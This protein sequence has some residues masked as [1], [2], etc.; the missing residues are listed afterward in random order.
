MKTLLKQDS[1]FLHTTPTLSSSQKLILKTLNPEL[2]RKLG[3]GLVLPT[4]ALIEGPNDSGKSVLCYQLC[5]GA[6]NIGFKVCFVT[7]E[8]SIKGLINA[9]EGLNFNVKYHFLAGNLKVIELHVEGLKWSKEVSKQYLNILYK[10]M[11]IASKKYQI[12]FVDSL[13]YIITNAEREDI[14]NFF[15]SILNLTEKGS[16]I[17]IT[18]HDYALDQDLMIRIRSICDTHI[19]LSIKEVSGKIMRLLKIL[20]AKGVEK[21]ADSVIGFEIDPAFGLKVLP[22]SQA[23]I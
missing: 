3:D 20:K 11:D 1:S 6:L 2:D 22:F 23:R 17:F 16:S 9:M 19:V 12:F 5:H 8:Q 18:L 13:T 4:L 14:L 10:Y 15:T 7:T 21:T